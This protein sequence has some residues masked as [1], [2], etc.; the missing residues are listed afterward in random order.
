L[1]DHAGASTGAI[2]LRCC[3]NSGFL[4]CGA[5]VLVLRLAHAASMR[6]HGS[7]CRYRRRRQKAGAYEEEQKCRCHASHVS[8]YCNYE[9]DLRNPTLHKYFSVKVFGPVT[10]LQLRSALSFWIFEPAAAAQGLSSQL[11]RAFLLC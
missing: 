4:L 2:A 7:N 9:V 8:E 3:G 10:L 6:C 5:A 1:N 11:S